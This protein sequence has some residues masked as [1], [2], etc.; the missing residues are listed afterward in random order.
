M[1]VESAPNWIEKRAACRID[2]MFEALMQIV[3]RDVEQFNA[4]PPVSRH[5]KTAAFAR[6][7][8]GTSPLARVYRNGQDEL[9]STLT[10]SLLRSGIRI[11]AQGKDAAILGLAWDSIAQ[12]CLLMDRDTEHTYRVWQVSERT[13]GSFLFDD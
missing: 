12:S 13:L 2:L 9:E 10:F 4:L 7:G 11:E 1:T 5:E 8:D 3:E 6:N